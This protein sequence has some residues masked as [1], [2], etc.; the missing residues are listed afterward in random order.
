MRISD[1]LGDEPDDERPDASGDNGGEEQA[2]GVSDDP[3]DKPTRDG[4]SLTEILEEAAGAAAAATEDDAGAPAATSHVPPP[5][6]SEA[7]DGVPPAP[8]ETDTGPLLGDLEPGSPEAVHETPPAPPPDEVPVEADD[9]PEFDR[10]GENVSLDAGPASHTPAAMFGGGRAAELEAPAGGAAVLTRVI[11][12]SDDDLLPTTART[13]STRGPRAQPP[14][15]TSEAMPTHLDPESG[16]EPEPEPTRRERRAARSGSSA[17][18]KAT[19][20][21][22]KE[23]KRA[24]RAAAKESAATQED[25]SPIPTGADA[26]AASESKPWYKKEISLGK[27]KR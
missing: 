4:R 7:V 26:S 1:L 14:P 12:P 11:E 22:D 24:E 17:D 15:T 19:R 3:A 20:K 5:G 6:P 25:V 8:R 27:K 21:A 13:K 2:P 16:D 23:Q 10:S 18:K 9:E